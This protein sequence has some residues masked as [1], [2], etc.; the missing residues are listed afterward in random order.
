MIPQEGHPALVLAG[1]RLVLR[2]VAGDRGEAGPECTIERG[3]SRPR[4][5]MGVDREL[6]SDGELDDGL[7]LAASEESEEATEDGGGTERPRPA[8]R[9]DPA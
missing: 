2:Q 8:S 7:V 9:T 5:L 6:L 1:G 3:E 4:V